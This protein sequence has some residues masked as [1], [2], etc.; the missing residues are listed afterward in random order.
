VKRSERVVAFLRPADRAK[1]GA[2]ARARG[3]EAGAVVREILERA[4]RRSA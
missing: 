2:I 3:L 4:L 1:L